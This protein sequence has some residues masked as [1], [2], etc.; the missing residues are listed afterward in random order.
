MRVRFCLLMSSI[1]TGSA[2]P[3]GGCGRARFI[4]AVASKH[5]AI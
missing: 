4:R 1:S 2:I 3:I 5:S